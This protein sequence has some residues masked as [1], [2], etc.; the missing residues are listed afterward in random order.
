MPFFAAITATLAD[1][2]MPA[3]IDTAAT[4]ATAG[5]SDAAMLSA[6]TSLAGD[7]MSYAGQQSANQT[8]IA[9]ANQNEAW[10]TQM[11]NT[12]MQRRVADLKAAGLNPL[13]SV[14]SGG[15]SMPSVSMPT[16]QNAG[17]AFG[18]VGNQ[19]SSAM[20]MSLLD[21]QKKAIEAQATQANASARN[22]DANTDVVIPATLKNMAAQYNL[23][24]A[25]A[26]NVQ[27]TFQLILSQKTGQD[28]E[29]VKSVLQ[30]Q[31]MSMDTAAK[32][33]FINLAIKAGLL[34][35]AQT[36]AQTALTR[37]QKGNVETNTGLQ[38]AQT[39]LTG[40][41][42]QESIARTNLTDAQKKNLDL[43]VPGLS[44][45]AS[46]QKSNFGKFMSWFGMAGSDASKG[47]AGVMSI[48]EPFMAMGAF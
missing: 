25:Q 8:N 27:A 22:T 29:N 37:A 48:A 41:Q 40:Q 31:M 38:S 30:A 19:V 34:G 26:N 2:A 36:E 12:Q 20:Q 44:N 15:A 9:L 21:A 33:T 4:A 18:N 13:L 3:A 17:A 47:M 35:N 24:T 23:T 39:L 10:Q 5:I 28:L 32:Q 11:S 43:L 14:Q 6:G 7:A 16:V 45:T 46:Y 42:V 1:V